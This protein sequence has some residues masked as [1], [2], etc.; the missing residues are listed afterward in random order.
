MPRSRWLPGLLLCSL[1]LSA[2]H[3]A[4]SGGPVAEH[5]RTIADAALRRQMK[6]PRLGEVWYRREGRTLC[7]LV[8]N[9]PGTDEAGWRM[10]MVVLESGQSLV[11]PSREEERR[12]KR[13]VLEKLKLLS[14][15]CD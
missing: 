11:E 13:L 4:P 15:E 6:A 8:R 1:T 12:D 2:A 9:T 5:D 10:F 14:A 7:G 3:A